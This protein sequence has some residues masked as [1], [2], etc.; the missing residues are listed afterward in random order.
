MIP[1]LRD[2]LELAA[3]HRIDPVAALWQ[4]GKLEGSTSTNR[5]YETLAAPILIDGIYFLDGIY[6]AGEATRNGKGLCGFRWLGRPDSYR[7]L[8]RLGR[9]NSYPRFRRLGRPSCCDS[10][11]S[12]A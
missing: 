5:G 11:L 6:L 4:I 1:G 9:P 12:L 2:Q 10:E 8:G 7:R 3:R